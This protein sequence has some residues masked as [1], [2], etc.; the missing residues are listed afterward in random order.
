MKKLLLLGLLLVIP[1][2]AHAQA[3]RGPKHQ[4]SL[5]W[6]AATGATGY[7]VYRCSGTCTATTGAFAVINSSSISGTI[8]VDSGVVNG[9]TYSWCVTSLA[10]SFESACSNIVTAT[11]PKDLVGAPTGFSVAAQ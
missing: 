3:P 9:S 6:T 7:N 2:L 4:A 10:T 5:S 8:F 11:I 1:A